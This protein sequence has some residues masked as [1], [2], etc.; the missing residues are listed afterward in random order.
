MAVKSYGNDA[1]P[2]VECLIRL[3]ET[4]GDTKGA[5][6]LQAVLQTAVRRAII[7]S[8][9]ST[10]SVKLSPSRGA[11]SS[12]PGVL[13]SQFLD[14]PLLPS[15][16]RPLLSPENMEAAL[17]I[18]DTYAAGEHE[19]VLLVGPSG[20]GKTMTA[21]WLAG[22][23]GR[24]LFRLSFPKI[25]NSFLGKTA[26]NLAGSLQEVLS[27][28]G[29]LFLDEMDA[30]FR[31]RDLGGD[32]GEMHRTVNVLLME[33]DN[34]AED[35]P[36]FAATNLYHQVDKA[37]FRRFHRTLHFDLPS[38]HLR[39]R[40]LRNQLPPPSPYFVP[41]LIALTDGFSFADM[42]KI[43]RKILP[44]NR[45]GPVAFPEC[46]SF[47]LQSAPPD[48]VDRIRNFVALSPQEQASAMNDWGLESKII[49]GVFNVS[50]A[51]VAR[52]TGARER[53]EDDE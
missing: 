41:T 1:V 28:G 14:P 40:Y 31:A 6:K 44:P 43:M 17:A 11:T 26:S 2:E 53:L 29:I 34:A 33:I 35:L 13:E 19:N 39:E 5:A 52:W 16:E 7:D 8:H 10:P 47:I 18:A 42:A 36:I 12:Q 21:A 23:I 32:H 48:Q 25:F 37:V 38:R 24:P 20:T 50:E 3:L 4:E 45:R 46:L 22:K 15:P 49:A 27:I 51:L 9:P 30:V